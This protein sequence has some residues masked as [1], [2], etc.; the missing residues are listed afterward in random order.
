METNMQFKHNALVIAANGNEIGHLS[1]VV[2][3]QEKKEVT[4]IV[5]HMNGLF[6]KDEKL[7]PIDQV[8][9]A[10]E[11]QI[12][13]NDTA[14]ELDG[15]P[16]YEEKQYSPVDEGPGMITTPPIAA[17]P[18][19]GVPQPAPPLIVTPGTDRFDPVSGRDK[20]ETNPDQNIPTGSVAVKLGA[21]V[22]SVDGERLGTLES[23][24]VAEPAD[25]PITHLVVSGGF[26]SSGRKLV[27]VDL[28]GRFDP[29]DIHLSAAAGSLEQLDSLTE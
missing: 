1:R 26:L 18:I 13:L 21:K 15:L 10:Y 14:G 19:S 16:L 11:D 27:P 23:V 4:H 25:H 9:E 6:N 3:N 20:F 2:V 22:S 7:V 12:R 5:V 24:L 28:I 29:E 17:A 8:V